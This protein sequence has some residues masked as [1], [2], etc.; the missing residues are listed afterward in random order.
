ME[1]SKENAVELWCP[2]LQVAVAPNVTT[3]NRRGYGSKNTCMANKCMMW[4]WVNKDRESGYC[5]LSVRR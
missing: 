2:M 5:G 4:E 3:S 1:V